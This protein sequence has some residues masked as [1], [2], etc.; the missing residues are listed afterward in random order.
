MT[1]SQTALARPHVKGHVEDVAFS[2][3]GSREA[4]H[5]DCRVTLLDA[6][7][8]HLGLTGTKKGCDHGQCGACTVIVDGRRVLSCLTL[9]ASCEGRDVV[10][11][12]GL[13]SGSQL[14]PLQQAFIRHD[15]LQC[16]FCTPGQLCSMVALLEEARNGEASFVTPDLRHGAGPLRLSVAEI[17]ERMSGNI[18]RC[19]AYLHLIDAFREVQASPPA[20]ATFLAAEGA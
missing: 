9:L 12:E 14:H 8:D 3:N 16:G 19:G 18:C 15:A 20:S 10:T 2:V 11:V 17:K 5:L 6:L 4:V 7:R 13:A 1:G